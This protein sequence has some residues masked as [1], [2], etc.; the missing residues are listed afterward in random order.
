MARHHQTIQQQTQLQT[1]ATMEGQLGQDRPIPHSTPTQ[2]WCWFTD[3]DL[4]LL[5]HYLIL[6]LKG[7]ISFPSTIRPLFSPPLLATPVI[8][9]WVGWETSS[10]WLSFEMWPHLSRSNLSKK[11]EHQSWEAMVGPG[12]HR[13]LP[14]LQSGKKRMNSR[15]HVLGVQEQKLLMRWRADQHREVGLE[16]RHRLQNHQPHHIPPHNQLPTYFCLQSS[17]GFT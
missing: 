11:L 2:S 4:P 13:W 5:H 7:L 3:V 16:L 8:T 1:K 15:L 17:F 10:G 9:N 12:F 6:K 14:S